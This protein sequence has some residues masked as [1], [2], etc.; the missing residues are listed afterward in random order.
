[1]AFVKRHACKVDFEPNAM[2]RA[3]ECGD[4]NNNESKWRKLKDDLQQVK[5]T[6]QS[7]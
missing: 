2:S 1:M 4:F 7:F 5:K 3:I 6:K